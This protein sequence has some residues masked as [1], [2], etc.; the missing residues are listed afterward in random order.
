MSYFGLVNDKMQDKW[1]K[2]ELRAYGSSIY[3][4]EPQIQGYTAQRRCD[5]NS[6]TD[7]VKFVEFHSTPRVEVPGT[8]EPVRDGC[9]YSAA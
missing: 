8:I 9:A 7:M 2:K 3:I 1:E 6:L 5:S 4:D